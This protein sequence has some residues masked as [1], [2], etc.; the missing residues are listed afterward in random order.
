MLYSAAA[1][2]QENN[3]T[4]MESYIW[5][6]NGDFTH[7]D[8][9]KYNTQIQYPNNYDCSRHQMGME[10]FENSSE[11]LSDLYTYNFAYAL[12]AFN[13]DTQDFESIRKEV[14]KHRRL[15][16][17]N[18]KI[19]RI[20]ISDFQRMYSPMRLIITDMTNYI[21]PQ[22]LLSLN[23]VLN[24]DQGPDK[25]LRLPVVFAVENTSVPKNRQVDMPLPNVTS[26][27][28]EFNLKDMLPQ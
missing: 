4:D 9:I 26:L 1:E 12:F 11:N 21:G 3:I 15:L 20:N 2:F 18:E 6:A 16:G 28:I 24:E 10:R 7:Q 17:K 27:S 8:K 22:P 14:I 5:N 25:K 23:L 13:E 19:V